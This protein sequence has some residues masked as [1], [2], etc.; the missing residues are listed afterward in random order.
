MGAIPKRCENCGCPVSPN[1]QYCKSC[2]PIFPTGNLNK[3][4]SSAPPTVLPSGVVPPIPPMPTAKTNEVPNTLNSRPKKRHKR[5]LIVVGILFVTF[6]VAAS[7][8]AYLKVKSDQEAPFI[9]LGNNYCSNLGQRHPD[10]ASHYIATRSTPHVISS[11]QLQSNFDAVAGHHR[12]FTGCS[13][14]DV[15]QV[16]DS[17]ASFNIT[18]S[19]IDGYKKKQSYDAFYYDSGRSW[20]INVI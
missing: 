6:L 20:K 18:Y 1:Q 3:A 11:G 12:E 19:F 17:S 7:L 8:L 15:T 2:A 4:S 14:S 16:G 10:I 9:A 13:V 5:S